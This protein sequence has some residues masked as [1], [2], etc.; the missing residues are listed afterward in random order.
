MPSFIVKCTHIFM[1]ENKSNKAIRLVKYL[2]QLSR[3]R[4][5]A[6]LNYENYKK[7]VGFSDLFL[8]KYSYA[9]Y[10]FQTKIVLMYCLSSSIVPYRLCRNCL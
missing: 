2:E 1:A 7:V 9:P 4:S 3:L 10:Y 5:P 8:E 6:V